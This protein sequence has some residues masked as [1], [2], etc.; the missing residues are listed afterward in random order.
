MGDGRD[1]LELCSLAERAAKGDRAAFAGLVEAT[2]DV[3][4]RVALRTTGSAQDAEDVVQETFV[5]A[6]SSLS[7]VDDLRAIR[8]WLCAVAR[9]A[10]TDRVRSS[11]RR[12]AWSID[13]PRD[14]DAAP[15]RDA[16]VADAPG[17]DVQL[18][19]AQAGAMLAGAI[20][21]LKEKHRVV[22]TLREID[23]LGYEEIAEALGVAVGTVESR[24][25]RAREALVKKLRHTVR[26]MR[27]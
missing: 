21:A 5:R 27:P 23:G 13:A 19:S 11:A 2:K 25:H 1:D 18:E 20:A 22:L 14:D 12:R 24:L 7:R 6:W 4:Y 3:V 16:L 26:E 8:A 15:L 9:N 10:A 17:P